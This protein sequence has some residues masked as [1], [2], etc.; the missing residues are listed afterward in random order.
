MG[1]LVDDVMEASFDVFEGENE[2][3]CHDDQKPQTDDQFYP[4]NSATLL[5]GVFG[6]LLRCNLSGSQLR[7]S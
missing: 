7:W 3:K 1:D 5:S 2:H 4:R 6:W